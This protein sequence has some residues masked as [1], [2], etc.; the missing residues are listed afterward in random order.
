MSNFVSQVFTLIRVM[1]KVVIYV[2]RIMLKVGM[3]HIVVMRNV[4]VTLGVLSSYLRTRPFH[5][6]LLC[7]AFSALLL[8]IVLI[9]VIQFVTE[10]PHRTLLFI[11]IDVILIF[12][13]VVKL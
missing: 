12:P 13:V 1:L 10:I 8:Y 7:A 3:A 2:L 11:L 4:G 6:I 5:A 9:N